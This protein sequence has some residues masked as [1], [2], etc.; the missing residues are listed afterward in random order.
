MS[1]TIVL[2]QLEESGQ[3]AETFRKA[4]LSDPAL[5]EKVELRFLN[6]EDD[7]KRAIR[8]AEIV[9]CGNMPEDVLS[10]AVRLKWVSFWSAGLDHKITSALREHSPLI[11]NASGVHAAN[12]AEH[13]LMFML[14]FNR[15]MNLHFRDQLESKWGHDFDARATGADELTGR[16]LGIIGLGRI[17][18]ALAKRAKAFEMQVIATKR[19]LSSRHSEEVEL[20]AVYPASDLSRL[21]SEADHVCLTVPHTPET[22][23]LINADNLALMKPTAYFYNIGRGKCVDEAALIRALQTGMIAGAGL[24]VFETEPLPSESPLWKMENVLITPHNSGLTPYY[25]SRAAVLFVE[26][27]KRYLADEPLKNRYE[28]KRGY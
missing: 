3:D 25:F 8:G 5:D 2:I 6:G 18:E 1:K 17:G 23:H 11:T 7:F 28:E 16:T 10:N 4:V 12:I 14:M 9:V 22:H 21:L 15:R 26:N 27:L 24:D 13:V 19:D 20:D